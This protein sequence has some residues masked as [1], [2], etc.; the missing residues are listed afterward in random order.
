MAE[1]QLYWY[2]PSHACVSDVQQPYK[3]AVSGTYIEHI[4]AN[5]VLCVRVC[6]FVSATV[7]SHEEM[8]HRH[9]IDAMPFTF[10]VLRKVS[11]TPSR[12]LRKNIKTGEPS[13]A[14]YLWIFYLLMRM[15]RGA[16]HDIIVIGCRSNH[17]AFRSPPVG[18]SVNRH[19]D[20]HDTHNVD[21]YA[22]CAPRHLTTR[23]R[24]AI[25]PCVHRIHI[26]AASGY[27]RQKERPAAIKA[28]YRSSVYGVDNT[29]TDC[30]R[31]H[32]HGAWIL[33]AIRRQ[34]GG[35]LCI[36]TL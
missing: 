16:R 20:L 30:S 34:A 28:T 31:E 1:Q 15:I 12:A 6:V 35:V 22:I 32:T 24:R 3:A 25:F 27:G 7:R 21:V 4:W 29:T 18:K 19:D 14:Y 17:P 13:P 9:R 8:Q 26:V 36:S 10:T 23:Q 11:K 5:G 2:R 33:H